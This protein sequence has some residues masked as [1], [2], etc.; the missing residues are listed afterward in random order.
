MELIL[1]TD[2]LNSLPLLKGFY[3]NPANA[4]RFAAAKAVAAR[5]GVTVAEVVLAYL[6]NQPQQVIPIFGASSPARVEESVKAAALKLSAEEL[7]ELRA[8]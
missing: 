5:H 6:V 4:G 2:F 1:F 8:E 3:D 7:A